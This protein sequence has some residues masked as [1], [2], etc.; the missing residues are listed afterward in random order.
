MERLNLE[1][2]QMYNFLSGVKLQMD[3][4][5]M[6][7]LVSSADMEENGYSTDVYFVDHQDSRGSIRLTESG[8]VKSFAWISREL[9]AF[10]EYEKPTDDAPDGRTRVYTANIFGNL[11]EERCA[12]TGLMTLEGVLAGEKLVLSRVD[13]IVH[14]KELEGLSG[15]AYAAR[16]AMLKEKEEI[17]TVFDEYPFWFNGRGVI[18]KTRKAVY[19][20]RL[21][22]ENLTR[23][24]PFGFRTE[25]L[26]AEGNRIVYNGCQVEPV[27]NYLTGAYVYD[28]ANGTT[29]CVQEEGVCHIY[30][31][32][33]WNGDAV[34]V[35][36]KM[37]HYSVSQCPDLTVIDPASGARTVLCDYA[38]EINVGNPV[39]SDSRLGGGYDLRASGGWLYFIMGVADA[40]HLYRIDRAGHL[41]P[42]LEK[43]GSVDCFDVAQERI[44]LVAMHDMRLQ[45]LYCM[46]VGEGKAARCTSWNDDFY[47]SRPPVVPEKLNFV[48]ADGVEIHGFVL[49]PVGY[50][51]DRKYPAILD[52]HGGPHLSY[53]AVYYHEMQYWAY[54]GYFVIYC[55]PRGGEGRGNEFGMLSG[56]FGTIDYDDLMAFCDQALAAYPAM[57]AARMGVTGGSYGGFMTNWIIGHTGRFAAAVSQ[58]SISNFVS[59]EG[60]SDIGTLFAQ[61]Q[62]MATTHTN[63]EKMWMHSPLKY[64]DKCTTPTLFIHAEQDY[65]CWMVEALQMYTTLINNGVRTRLCLFHNENHELSRGGRP[66]GRIRRLSEITDWMDAFLK[67]ADR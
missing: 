30:G 50:R 41:E 40:S 67:P 18:N 21:N 64:A 24:T 14:E 32:T 66:K 46:K 58:R 17:A 3:G 23:V 60:T 38:R 6:A 35:S 59:M 65:R 36:S 4:E 15:E 43:D 27:E 52:I 37:D 22:G 25:Y 53:G 47:L 12:F 8:K 57:D 29:T 10:T 48:N 44:C 7:Y 20:C 63:V 28:A 42:V 9:L 13:N 39:G 49:K 61:G 51:S 1:D 54:R 34:I 33:L 45:E 2:F 56:R 11:R 62:V 26:F 5:G 55:N 31:V 19:T 16:R